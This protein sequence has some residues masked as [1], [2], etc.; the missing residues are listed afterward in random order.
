MPYL[1]VVMPVY[2]GEQFLETAIDSILLQT[3]D[4]FEFI[5][6]NDGSTDDT[7]KII[8]SYNDSRIK[9]FEDTHM[10]IANALNKGISVAEGTYI[11]RQDADDISVLY[12]FERQAAF[13]R[14]HPEI[15]LVGSYVSTIDEKEVKLGNIEFPTKDQD[16]RLSILDRNTFIHGSTMFCRKSVEKIGKYN[17][18][19]ALMQDYDLWLRIVEHYAVANISEVLYH[20]RISAE[21]ISSRNPELREVY[22]QMAKELALQRRENNS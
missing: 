12:R 16:I 1:S 21:S 17:E 22:L 7:H 9:I 15:K 18:V 10:G 5:I 3:F 2:N 6:I 11:A 4:D 20:Y 14:M 19:F 8:Y 13:L